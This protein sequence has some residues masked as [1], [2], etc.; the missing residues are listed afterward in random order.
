MRIEYTKNLC[1]DLLGTFKKRIE[2]NTW[3][4]GTTKSKAKEKA[5]KMIFFAGYS[6]DYPEEFLFE[7]EAEQ[8][9][10]WAYRFISYLTKKSRIMLIKRIFRND[11]LIEQ[12][13]LDCYTLSENTIINN[14]YY[15]PSNNAMVINIPNLQ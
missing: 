3:M 10:E 12:R 2:K 6:D 8:E 7:N 15:D 5:E 13:L 4:S 14:A 9:G 11:I 1:K